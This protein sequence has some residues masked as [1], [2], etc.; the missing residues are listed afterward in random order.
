VQECLT[1]VHHRSGSKN[2]TIRIARE[3]GSVYLEV[4]DQGKGMSPEKLSEVHS[5]GS[6][7]GIGGMRERVH[8][9]EGNMIIQSGGCG[10]KISVTLPFWKPGPDVADHGPANLGLGRAASG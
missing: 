6:G 8:Q 7:V 10:T 9:L 3:A 1:N 2:A 4:Q 5:Q